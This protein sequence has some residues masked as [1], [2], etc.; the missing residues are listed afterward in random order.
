MKSRRSDRSR[1]TGLGAIA[2]TALLVAALCAVT[3]ASAS[4]SE[5]TYHWFECKSA[6]GAEALYEDA[7]CSKSGTSNHYRWAQA[8]SAVPLSFVQSAGVTVNWSHAGVR[9]QYSCA[10]NVGEGSAV[11][12]SSGPEI[13][14]ALKF[15]GCRVTEPAGRN[16]QLPRGIW[17]NPLRGLPTG[18]WN[19]GGGEAGPRYTFEA[20]GTTV[21]AEF[22]V[23]G[24][25][26]PS[27]NAT[28]KM[29]GLLNFDLANEAGL[30]GAPVLMSW[31]G[32]PQK[33]TVGGISG[34]L[35][36]EISLKSS[37]GGRI[38]Y[39]TAP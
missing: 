26:V 3:G 12:G 5:S 34:L 32:V 9:M 13:Q 39:A 20:I 21:L 2:A 29:E 8:T 15:E 36:G 37:L 7:K 1:L 22:H 11:N 18:E 38:K 14:G 31:S 23:E 30:E 6:S 16:C 19:L 24:C 4:A 25:T 35:T 28:Y 17:T 10:S 27:L 33:F